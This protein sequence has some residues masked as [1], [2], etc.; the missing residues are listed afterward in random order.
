MELLRDPD[1]LA[2]LIASNAPAEL[3]REDFDAAAWLADPAHFALRHGNDLGMFEAGDE[4]PGPLT[5][6]VLFASRGRAAL[7]VARAMLA[8]AFAFG[9]TQIL[10]ETPARFRHALLFVRRLGF[11]TYGEADRGMGWV[12]LSALDRPGS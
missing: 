3:V 12:V 1:E 11:T 9:A 2:R 6:H 7:D 8:Q 10:G 5:A 4:W